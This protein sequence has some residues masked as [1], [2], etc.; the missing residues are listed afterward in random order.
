[1]GKKCA[2]MMGKTRQIFSKRLRD[3]RLQNK[4]TTKRMAADLGVSESAVSLWESG[5]RFPGADMLDVL[6]TYTKKPACCLLCIHDE[7]GHGY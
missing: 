3:W 2:S 4:L 1:M 7:C 6:S 5:E